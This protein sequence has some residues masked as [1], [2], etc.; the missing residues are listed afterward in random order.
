MLVGLMVGLVLAVP[1][2]LPALIFVWYLNS[3]GV[4]NAIRVAR[5][6]RTMRSAAER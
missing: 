5:I 4:I 2:V 6:Q 3:G 1:L